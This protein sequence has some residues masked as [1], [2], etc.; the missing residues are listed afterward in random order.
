MPP[1]VLPFYLWVAPEQ[2]REG[3]GHTYWGFPLTKIS[4]SRTGAH[5]CTSYCLHC[6]QSLAVPTMPNECIIA[7]VHQS[8]RGEKIG[9][10][11]PSYCKPFL[12]SSAL[13]LSLCHRPQKSPPKKKKKKKSPYSLFS[14][15]SHVRAAT[16]TRAPFFPA[17]R[18]HNRQ[19]RKRNGNIRNFRRAGGVK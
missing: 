15:H 5:Q 7:H 6:A 14:P 19:L 11:A 13:Y 4:F 1:V 16:P 9:T 2:W 10:V 12:L 3:E 17:R 8:K 18:R